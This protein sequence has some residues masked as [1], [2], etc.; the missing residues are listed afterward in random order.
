MPGSDGEH[1]L[2]QRYGTERRAQVFYERQVLDHLN[3]D[4]QDFVRR[5]ELVFVATADGRGEADCSLR[6]G[7]PG[8]V[9][10]LDRWTV[11]YPELRGNGVM[12]SLGNLV[13]NGHVGLLFV[14]FFRDTIGL[15]VNGRARVVD[16]EA[17]ARAM[18]SLGLPAADATGARPE[19]WVVVEVQEA[20]IHCSK[21]IPLLAKLDKA[22]AWGTDD[23]ARKG[24]DY[25]NVRG[26][27]A[28]TAARPG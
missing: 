11:A 15:H 26:G 8:F 10:V 17:M 14:D 13:E 24:G 21:H 12:A 28:V 3:E 2:Q 25:F 6:A 9:Q 19:R 27:A 16:D 23:A 18:D 7:P 22:I 20:Y 4:M 1:Q 5:M